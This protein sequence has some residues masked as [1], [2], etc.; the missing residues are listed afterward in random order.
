MIYWNIRQISTEPFTSSLALEMRRVMR[1]QAQAVAADDQAD[2]GQVGQ[3]AEVHK[4]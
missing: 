2:A 3:L 1:Q 4:G